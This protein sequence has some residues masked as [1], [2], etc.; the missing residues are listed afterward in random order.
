MYHLSIYLLIYFET[1][2]LC[3]ALAVLKLALK[4]SLALNPE[5]LLPLLT[6][7]GIKGVHHHHVCFILNY[8]Y[9]HEYIHV[10]SQRPGMSGLFYFKLH[11]YS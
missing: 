9:I 2:F 3:V 1:G 5:I 6:S 4:T 11:I 8:T 10:S 7:A